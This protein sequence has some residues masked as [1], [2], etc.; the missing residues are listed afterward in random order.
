MTI[1]GEGAGKG[2]T[3]RPVK[4]DKYNEN[5]DHIK[6]PKENTFRIKKGKLHKVYTKGPNERSE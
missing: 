5:F 2:D 4:H 3:Y 1:E 6:F